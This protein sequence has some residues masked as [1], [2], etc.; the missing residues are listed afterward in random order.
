[1]EVESLKSPGTTYLL[2]P[3]LIV[4]LYGGL[5]GK[6]SNEGLKSKGDEERGGYFARQ[7][8]RLGQM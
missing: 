4:Q 1:M 3:L 6:E 5:G 2:E 8:E 7:K